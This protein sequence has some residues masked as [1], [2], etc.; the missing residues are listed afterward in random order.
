MLAS[1][2]GDT[3]LRPGDGV[4]SLLPLRASLFWFTSELERYGVSGICSRRFLRQLF[5]PDSSANA[6]A[7]GRSRALLVLVMRKTLESVP[8]SFIFLGRGLQ[9]S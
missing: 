3:H 2:C 5:L 4:Y 7:T 6:I 9:R 8:S 1:D